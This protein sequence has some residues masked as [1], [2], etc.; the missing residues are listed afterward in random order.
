MK[1]TLYIVE[2][3]GIE[4]STNGYPLLNITSHDVPYPPVKRHFLSSQ[5]VDGYLSDYT[6]MKTFKVEADSESNRKSA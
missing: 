4:P 6:I 5:T 3:L 2:G 1:K